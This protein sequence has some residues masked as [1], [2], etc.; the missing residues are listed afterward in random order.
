MGKKLRQIVSTLALDIKAKNLDDRI[1]FRYLADKFKDKIAYFLRL[2][3]KSRE[4]VR[5][6]SIW[7][8]IGCVELI[9]VATNT[10]GF[11]DECNTLKRSKIKVPNVY[12][13][14]YGLLIKVLTIDGRISFT[15]INSNQYK[16]FTKL[17][18]GGNGRFFFIE[19]GYLYF[20]NTDIESV[21]VLLIPKEPI[22]V[23][24]LNNP[25]KC[26]YPLDGEVNYSDYLIILAQ[27][28]VLK[29]LLPATGIVQDEKPNDNT[30]LK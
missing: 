19:D 20:P 26:A 6:I 5:D 9:E 10:C 7:K 17:E 29:E 8:T 13:T 2:E 27:Q 30:N 11:I 3:A 15:G 12:N 18:Y 23:D 14:N 25:C 21:K 28:E 24:V 22:E 16:D 1:S 4:F